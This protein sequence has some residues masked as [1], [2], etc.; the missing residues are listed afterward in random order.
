MPATTT[1]DR[2]DKFLI[3]QRLVAWARS[4]RGFSTSS[5]VRSMDSLGPAPGSTRQQNRV[6]R[7]PGSGRGKTAGRGQKGQ[8]ARAS[9]HP[10]FEG[11]QTP[12][13]R[14]FPKVGF[15]SKLA[16]P[17]E[18][19]L[20]KLAA[21]V[22]AGRLDP[23]KPITMRELYRA[24]AADGVK[25]GVKILGTGS[26]KLEVPL[27]ITATRATE[28]AISRIEELGGSF[29]AQ[30]YSR[31]GLRALT[32]PEATLRKYA[33]L[34][35]RAR[36]TSRRTIEFYRDPEARGYMVDAPGAPQV[37]APYKKTTNKVSPLVAR[38]AELEKQD[39]STAVISGFEESKRI[40][41]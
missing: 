8:W 34:P 5:C 35:L 21:M 41:A 23:S 19:S 24:K 26:E 32:R 10:W 9:V 6:G 22:A 2:A 25:A 39:L 15:R 17:A 27:H 12:I 16:K 38:L 36:P 3:M 31:L 13:T 29:K 4:V 37:K 20:G 28:Q 33:R 40:A 11:G 1:L 30:Y 14:L 7:G 18:I